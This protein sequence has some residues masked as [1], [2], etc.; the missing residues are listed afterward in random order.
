[1]RISSFFCGC[2]RTYPNDLPD[3][4][5]SPGPQ[6][7]P[8][9]QIQELAVKPALKTS[10]ENSTRTTRSVSFGANTQIPSPLP[11]SQSDP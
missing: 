6:K 9:V 8:V 7:P 10:T 11:T 5:V 3:I 1:M 4:T 2:F